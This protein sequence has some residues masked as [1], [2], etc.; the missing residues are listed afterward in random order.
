M[1]QNS[2]V[3]IRSRVSPALV[4]SGIVQTVDEKQGTAT[5]ADYNLQRT[6][7]VLMSDYT[8]LSHISMKSYTYSHV[9]FDYTRPRMPDRPAFAYFFGVDG[10]ISPIHLTAKRLCELKGTVLDGR[11]IIIVSLDDT[12]VLVMDEAN[13]GGTSQPLN[14]TLRNL[15]PISPY[16]GPILFLR[17]NGLNTDEICTDPLNYR[18][19]FTPSSAFEL[20]DDGDLFKTTP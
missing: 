18:E 16:K 12:H 5:I 6:Y 14:A 8:I 13:D 7:L 3:I 4:L 17:A 1:E 2:H 15:V 20:D 11:P 10:S 9:Q 19:Y